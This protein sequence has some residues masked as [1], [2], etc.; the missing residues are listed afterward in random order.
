MIE[1]HLPHQVSDPISISQ[2]HQ[3]TPAAFQEHD[4]GTPID[5][6]DLP[7]DFWQRDLRS[8]LLSCLHPRGQ[9][10]F[11]KKR[12]GLAQRH[13]VLLEALQ[14]TGVVAGAAAKGFDG[15]GVMP[16]AAQMAQEE[17]C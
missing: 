8:A 6:A 11:E 10:P 14:Q 1:D 5:G 4:S 17:S 12:V 7:Q 13:R 3:N 15:Q 2:R 16:F 9:G